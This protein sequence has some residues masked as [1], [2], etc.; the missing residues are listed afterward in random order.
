MESMFEIKRN[1]SF[2]KIFA[3]IIDHMPNDP[4]KRKTGQEVMMAAMY[5]EEALPNGKDVLET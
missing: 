3:E 1:K 5:G 4:N 2:Q